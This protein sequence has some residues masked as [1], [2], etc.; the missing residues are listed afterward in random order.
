M[1]TSPM[2]IAEAAEH[3]QMEALG[4]RFIHKSWLFHL[5]D[6]N[7]EGDKRPA[8]SRVL[9]GEDPRLPV[10]PERPTLL[11][12][13]RLRF[14]PSQQHLLQSARLARENGLPEKIILA[15]L[16]HDV[17]TAAFIRSDHGYWGAQMVEPY[18]DEEIT[19]AIRMHQ[20]IKFFPDEERGFEYPQ[21]YRVMF[22]ED[23]QP[24]DYVVA[25]YERAR[26]HPWYET[27]LTICKNDDYSFNPDLSVEVEE[28]ED[29]VG[30]HFKQPQEGLG[31]D[32]SPSAH[33]WRTLRRP[34]NAL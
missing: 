1:S 21:S 24:P 34:A 22:G 13:F 18:V 29:I 2:D 19:W 27:A 20:V 7:L 23:Y 3:E 16:L 31:N 17:G 15:C 6:G 32:N 11:D 28:F 14:S 33:M 8:G 9:M 4:A 12:F 26:A 10:M 25:E 30:R 5:A